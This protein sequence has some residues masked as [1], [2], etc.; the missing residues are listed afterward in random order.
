MHKSVGRQRLAAVDLKRRP[1][2]AADLSASYFHDE[3]TRGRIPRIEIE[4]PET[5]E[6]PAGY[7][8]QIQRSRSRAAHAVGAQRDLVV[9]VNIRVLVP[10]VARKAG[11]H[12]TLLQQ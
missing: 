6:A 8:A 7:V 5:V 12:Q 11:G 2:E 9:E 3:H 10:L 1:V 4:F